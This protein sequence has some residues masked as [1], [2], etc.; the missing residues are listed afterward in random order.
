M[1]HLR[2]YATFENKETVKRL[3]CFW[4]GDGK[5]W[6]FPRTGS[7]KD[8][9][10]LINIHERIGGQELIFFYSKTVQKTKETNQD[11]KYI[12]ASWKLNHLFEK[13]T[14]DQ[15][16]ERYNTANGVAKPKPIIIEAPQKRNCIICGGTL[17]AIGTSR[18]NGKTHT[19]W[20]TRQYHKN[21]WIQ[22]N[23]KM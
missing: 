22:N 13:M 11:N 4:E 14:K 7:K 3:G 8:L 19:D 10:N 17:R 2:V 18:L 12:D 5:Y 15:I 21:C 20:D 16:Y 6:H 23:W 1:N 9:D